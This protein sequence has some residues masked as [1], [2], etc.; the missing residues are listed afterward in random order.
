M[1]DVIINWYAIIAATLVGFAV[2]F[3]WYG[4][5]FGKAWMK[6]IGL[7]EEENFKN[8]Q[9]LRKMQFSIFSRVK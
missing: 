7:T 8:M 3:V 2:G 6:E 5:L 4:P 9:L 1:E